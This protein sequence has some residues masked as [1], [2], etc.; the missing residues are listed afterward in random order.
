MKSINIR[1]HENKEKLGVA[2]AEKFIELADTYIRQNNRFT[3]ALSGG[4]TP[5]IL[6]KNLVERFRDAVDWNKII[7]FWSDERYVPPDH[8]DSNAGM[9]VHYLINPLNMNSQNI[10]IVPTESNTP[11]QA[12]AKYEKTIRKVFNSTVDIP[13]FDLVLL[14]LGD[15]GHTASLFPGTD[16]LRKK[17]KLVAANWVPEINKWRITFTF[18]LLNSAKNIIFLISGENK[19]AVTEKIVSRTKDYPA[20]KVQPVNGELIWML[21]RAAGRLLAH[22]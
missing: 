11:Q 2:A 19:A 4:S 22:E 14:G 6:F 15:D 9:A 5:K 18:S 7:L 1:I 10:H 17:Q 13:Q 16:A 12:A 21:D 20:A 8:I 3:V